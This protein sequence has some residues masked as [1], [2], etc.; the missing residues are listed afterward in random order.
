MSA[1]AHQTTC[2]PSGQIVPTLGQGTWF[3]GD[4]PDLKAEEIRA[5]RRG[6][7]LGMTL[8]DTAEMYGSGAAETLV[9][10]AIQHCRDDVFLV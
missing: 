7:D 5:L 4:R 1:P 3:M 9:G 8:I 10:T 6:I 2:L